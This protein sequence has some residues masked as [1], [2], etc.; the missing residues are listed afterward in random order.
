MDGV[1]GPS[2]PQ[3]GVGRAFQEKVKGSFIQP[4]VTVGADLGA[5]QPVL[6]ANQVQPAQE[7]VGGVLV[8]GA[9]LFPD[10]VE[11]L[12]GGEEGLN[13]G[14]CRGVLIPP[15]RPGQPGLD[16]GKALDLT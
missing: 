8:P 3:V 2:G 10:L 5:L 14:G 6:V 4:G 15:G 12:Q 11:G 9:I 7:Q 16:L 13:R 1:Q